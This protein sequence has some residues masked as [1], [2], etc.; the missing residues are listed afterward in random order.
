MIEEKTNHENLLNA[1]ND[2]Q[3][4]V[5]TSIEGPLLVLAGAGS[6]KTR[7][8]IHRVAWL[9]LH[10]NVHPSN[11][12]VVTF[13]NRAAEELNERLENLFKNKIRSTWVGTFHSICTRILRTE[14]KFLKDYS[15]NF[16]IY[17]RDDQLSLLKRIFLIENIDKKAIPPEKVLNIISKQKSNIILPEDFFQYQDRN[18]V[19]ET[20]YNLY[21]QYNQTLKLENAMDFDDLLMNTALLLQNNFEVREKYQDQFKY[22]MV[23]EYQDTNFVQFKILRLLAEKHQNICVVGDDDQA[24]YGWRGANIKNILSFH[25]DYTNVKVVKLEQNYRSS[26]NILKLANEL[27]MINSQRHE[28]TLWSI[29]EYFHIPQLVEHNTEYD[30]AIFIS[31]LILE[32]INN[33]ITP[34]QIVVLYRTNFQSRIFESIF[35]ARKIKYQVI[36]SFGFFKRAEIKDLISWLRFLVNP[37]DMEAFLR[38]VNTPARG[39]GKT[40]IQNIYFYAQKNNMTIIKVLEQVQNIKTITP[41]ARNALN[42]FYSLINNLYQASQ[43]ISLPEIV[44]YIISECGLMHHYEMLDIKEMT[45]K[46]E[47]IHEFITATTEYDIEF[48]KEH[49]TPP[50]LNDYLCSLSLMSEVDSYDN[51]NETVKIMTMHSV[52]GLEFEYVLVV[53]LEEGII[54]HI[55]CLGN[56]SEIEEER[57]LLYVAITRAKKEVYLNFSHSRRVAGKTQYQNYSRFLKTLQ[58][59]LVERVKPRYNA[60]PGV[61]KEEIFEN[62][63]FPINKDQDIFTNSNKLTTRYRNS[64]Y[65]TKNNDK[66]FLKP[67]LFNIVLE[68]EKFF[69]IGM[70]VKHEEFGIGTILSV[71]GAGQNAKLTISFQNGLL[72]KIHGRWVKHEF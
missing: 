59:P 1:L 62:Q 57:R 31:E 54:P 41:N 44:E 19:T 2:A 46:V 69:K 42:N 38:V 51:K 64:L 10:K 63:K 16:T 37:D 13:T 23:D 60:F 43:K 50:T 71:E 65:E 14:I 70:K 53:G 8:V 30:E 5:V 66:K 55:L 35:S 22:I 6:G 7:S 18:I 61:Y 12:L 67:K 9:I 48:K 15:S 17:D 29:N 58:E 56:E 68:N 11:I 45:D 32:K 52:K 33:G 26:K 72:K 25:T 27:I 21:V 34:S 24:I 36:G 40:T 3:K 20:F 47:N 39:I 4:E 28:K 49:G